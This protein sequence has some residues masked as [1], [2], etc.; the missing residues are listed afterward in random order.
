MHKVV[1]KAGGFA[2]IMY[3]YWLITEEDMT[4]SASWK[5]FEKKL[6]Y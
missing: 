4:I 1:A 5:N 2:R 3:M 6:K